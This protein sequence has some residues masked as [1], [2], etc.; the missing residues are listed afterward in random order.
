MDNIDVKTLINNIGAL[1]EVSAIVLKQY[2]DKG[3]TRNEAMSI[4]ITVVKSLLSS[5]PKK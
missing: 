5:E 3:F 2:T 1:A 4:V